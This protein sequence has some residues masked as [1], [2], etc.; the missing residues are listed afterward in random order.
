MKALITFQVENSNGKSLQ[1]AAS[2]CHMSLLL[3]AICLYCKVNNPRP[4]ISTMALF[5]SFPSMCCWCGKVGLIYH[6]IKCS[7]VVVEL[8]TKLMIA[9][10]WRWCNEVR[11]KIRS[12]EIRTISSSS[13][14]HSM[15][16]MF[17][18]F[19]FCFHFSSFPFGLRSFT[20]RVNALII[21]LTSIHL[22]RLRI[23]FNTH[24]HVLLF[25]PFIDWSYK[26]VAIDGWLAGWWSTEQQ[27]QWR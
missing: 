24:R 4:Q 23:P 6:A 13:L 16:S 12:H 21:Q 3:T 19:F 22:R 10:E 8:F 26:K 17:Y 15:F 14:P 27:W 9:E 25:V 11:L 7:C 2:L 5:A 18:F 20:E 1:F